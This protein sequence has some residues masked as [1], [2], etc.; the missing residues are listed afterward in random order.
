MKEAT[1]LPTIVVVGNNLPENLVLLNQLPVLAF[2][3]AREYALDCPFIM[4]QQQNPSLVPEMFLEFNGKTGQ[5]DSKFTSQRTR[6]S[7]EAKAIELLNL[8]P[9]PAVVLSVQVR[10][11]ATM[12]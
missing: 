7:D 10:Q 9:C 2:L 8:L 4:R 11:F 6:A 1:L 5:T 12:E 3:E